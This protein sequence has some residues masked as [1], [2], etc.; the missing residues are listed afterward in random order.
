MKSLFVTQAVA[1][2][3]EAHQGLSEMILVSLNPIGR[4]AG[5]D[6]LIVF[7]YSPMGDEFELSLAMEGNDTM[8]VFDPPYRAKMIGDLYPKTPYTI[9]FMNDTLLFPEEY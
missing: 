3:L 4:L 8:H 1:T 7:K 6:G 2:V 5:E 9:W